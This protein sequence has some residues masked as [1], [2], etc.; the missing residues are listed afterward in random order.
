MASQE[1]SGKKDVQHQIFDQINNGHNFLLSGGAG[2]GKTYTL[3]ETIKGVIRENPSSPIACMT[4]TNA[5]VKEIQ[6]RVGHQNLL[7]STIHEFLWANVKHFQKELKSALVSLANNPDVKRITIDSENPIPNSYF[8]DLAEGIQYKEYLNLK[9]GIISHDELIIIS[10]HLFSKYRVLCDIVKDKYPYIFIDEYQDT[11]PLV[12]EI[13]LKHFKS[14]NKQCVIGCFGDS[15]QSIYDGTVGDLNKYKEIPDGISEI[16]KEQNRRNPQSVIDLANLLRTDGITQK[17]SDDKTAPNM[18]NGMIKPGSICF[19][20]SSASD[21][22]EKA[23][24]YLSWDFENSKDSKELNLT[25]NLMAGKAGFRKLMDIYS[26]DKILNYRTRVK[27]YIKNNGI[28]DDFSEMTF[29]EVIDSLKAGKTDKE[30]KKINPTKGMQEFISDNESL[31][32]KALSSP[33]SSFSRLYVDKDQ[34]LDDKKQDSDEASSRGEK[35]DDLI[36]HLFKIQHCIHLYKSKQ[37]NEFIKT[38]DYR[39]KLTSIGQKSILKKTI[40]SLVNTGDKTIDQIIN[41]ADKKG[42]CKIDDRLKNFKKDK[43]YIYE[44]VINTSFKEFQNLYKYLEGFTP[45]STQHKTKGTEFLNVLVI[46]DNGRWNDYNFK[47]LFDESSGKTES[48]LKRTQKIFYVCCTRS[49][50]KLAVYFDSPSEA[51]IATANKWFG[52]ENVINIDQVA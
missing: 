10:H 49:M 51:I 4:Y 30:L 3:V 34:L 8:D 1:L 31:Y 26:N 45:Y 50:E 38:T 18:E 43:Q 24:T 6:N 17:P 25:H 37:Y 46:L 35:R 41:D 7:V 23:K 9:S 48:V 21:G 20:Y 28:T 52:K 11:N 5:A 19:L 14:S 32:S 42:I 27:N 15:M 40:D 16:R 47:Q 39:D 44:R 29:G 33:Y 12:I 22:L 13:F 36:K 2:S